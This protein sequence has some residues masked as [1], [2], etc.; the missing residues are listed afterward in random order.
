MGISNTI[1]SLTG[2]I[3]PLIVGA[4]TDEQNTL[5][6]WRI[7]FIITSVLLV[8]ASF[9]FIF[10]SSSEKQDW[11]DPIPSEVILDL[12]EETKKTKKLYS[13]LE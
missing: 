2:F 9:A 1:S 5:H 6:Q 8:I 10:F 4:L 12:P 11:A 7:V 3:T 13:P